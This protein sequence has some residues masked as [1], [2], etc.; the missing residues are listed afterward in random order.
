MIINIAFLISLFILNFL[1]LR[2]SITIGNIFNLIDHPISKR[3]LHSKPIPKIGGLVIFNIVIVN[4]FL[5]LIIKIQLI[6]I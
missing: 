1:V 3:S 5:F 2:K 4:C 6:L